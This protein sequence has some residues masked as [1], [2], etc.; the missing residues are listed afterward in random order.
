ML[1]NNPSLTLTFPDDTVITTTSIQRDSIHIQDNLFD[2]D[3]KPSSDLCDLS[4]IPDGTSLIDDILSEDGAI[5]AVLKDGTVPLFT[6]YLSDSFTWGIN[7][8]GE[9][10]LKITIE[11]TGSKLLQKPFADEDGTLIRRSFSA[12]VHDIN[13][14]CGELFSVIYDASVPQYIKDTV[15]INK[16]DSSK[17]CQQILD[18]VCFELGLAYDFDAAGDLNIRKINITDQADYT[19]SSKGTGDLLYSEGSSAISFTR[20]ARQYRQV[21]VKY[22][23]TEDSTVMVPVYKV[24]GNLEV[25]GGNWWDGQEQTDPIYSLT[26]DEFFQSGKT[27]YIQSGSSYVIATVTIGDPILDDTYYE[28]SGSAGLATMT[29]IEKGKDILYVYPDTLKPNRHDQNT[30]YSDGGIDYVA[31]PTGFRNSKWTL[32]QYSGTDKLRVLVD[33]TLSSVS[34]IYTAFQAWARIIRK[35]GTGSV[36]RAA[37]GLASGSEAQYTYESEWIHDKGQAAELATLLDGWYRFCDRQ[38]TFYTIKDMPLGS[39]VSINEN[40]F[41][42]KT[43]TV[44]ITSKEY[45]MHGEYPG[46]FRY[47]CRMI[48]EGLRTQKTVTGSDQANVPAPYVPEIDV[49]EIQLSTDKSVLDKDLRSNTLN[50]MQIYAITVGEVSGITLSVKDTEGNDIPV[51][52]VAGV[53]PRVDT[54]EPDE[55]WELVLYQN[56]DTEGISITATSGTVSSRISVSVNDLTQYYRFLGNYASDTDPDLLL[57]TILPGDFYL[58]TTTGVTRECLSVSPSLSWGD[59]S[60]TNADNAEKLLK[61]LE[62]A[63]QA[64]LQLETMSNPNTVSWFNTIIAAKAVIDNL[65]SRYITILNGGSIHSSAYSDTGTYIGPGSGFYLGSDGSLKCYSAEMTDIQAVNANISGNSSFHGSF[66]CTIIKTT[67]ESPSTYI[68]LDGSVADGAQAKRITDQMILNGLIS[69][70]ALTQTTSPLFPIQ[71]V[72]VSGISYMRVA[73]QGGSVQSGT[74]RYRSSLRFYDSS[75]TEVNIRNYVTCSK[76]SNLNWSNYLHSSN[77]DYGSDTSYRG[78]WATSGIQIRVL[79]GQSRLWV[80]VPDS[81]AASAL[82]SGMLFKASTSQSIDGVI[83]YPLY[84]KA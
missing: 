3:L 25:H 12:L 78:Q 18:E 26:L 44:L 82:S 24:D 52:P 47:T 28:Y 68:T 65:F 60:A 35:A 21:R 50:R 51:D 54:V 74:A 39:T 73:Y 33:N 16:I 43:Y 34:V 79:T 8:T 63:T 64:G 10:V 30:A 69:D 72:G 5:K 76:S 66:D 32:E 48:S 7:T 62:S 38:Y 23:T 77:Y 20:Q 57:N 83:G 41:T 37:D 1:I 46:V 71:I 80:D 67:P 84:V 11:D 61:A 14:R 19:L 22:S 15:L 13:V 36:Y 6:G 27:Y 55:Q 58:N 2:K 42:D 53:Y 45:S 75:R 9:D 56:Y 59:L 70:Y 49:S 81:N 29:D 4:I 31:A 40:L 17:T